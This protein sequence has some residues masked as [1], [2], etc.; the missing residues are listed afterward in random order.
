[1]GAPGRRSNNEKSSWLDI[2][3]PRRNEGDIHIAVLP[4]HVRKVIDRIVDDFKRIDPAH[5][6]DFDQRKAVSR[7]AVQ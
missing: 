3:A 2:G 4:G 6:T 1:V 7:R 5:A